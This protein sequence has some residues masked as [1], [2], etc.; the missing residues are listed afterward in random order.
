MCAY[1]VAFCVKAWQI[2]I[3]CVFVGY[4]AAVV[5]KNPHTERISD[6]CNSLSDCAVA[7]DAESFAEKLVGSVGDRG[8]GQALFP[9]AVLN[10]AAV[11]ACFAVML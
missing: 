7:D 1:D 8:E 6:F 5:C 4:A 10:K 11:C 9:A 3:F 2:G